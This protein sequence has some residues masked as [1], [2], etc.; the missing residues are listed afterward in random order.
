MR[1]AHLALELDVGAPCA[2]VVVR[3]QRTPYGADSRGEAGLLA[4]GR[5][6]EGPQVSR[7]RPVHPRD[8]D[9]AAQRD[10][11]DPVLDSVAPDLHERGREADVEAPR[12][13]PH[14]AG[15]GE[16][17]ELV[18]E[19][20][21]DEPTE[22]DDPRHAAASAPSASARAARSAS[23]RSSR[24]RTASV[25]AAA[26]VS[27]TTSGMPRNGRRPARNAATATSF[28]AL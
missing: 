14:R 24:S 6:G 15:D 5:L 22:P 9:E 21:Q 28:A 25:G 18:Q 23:T 7:G 12:P 19:D 3:I 26:S 2:V 27:P 20:E 8:P 10:H 13:H 4:D 11:P 1:G 16:V 17:T